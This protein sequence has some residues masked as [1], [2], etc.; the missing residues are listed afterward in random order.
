MAAIIVIVL[1]FYAGRL[2]FLL[3]EQTKRQH[4][5][6]HERIDSI[7]QSIQTIASATEQGQCNISEASIRISRLLAA[8]PVEKLPDYNSVYPAIHELTS[9]L[10]GFATHEPRKQLSKNERKEQD[11][12][13]ELHEAEL[14]V[15]VLLEMKTLK[16]FA[17]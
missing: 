3:N 12:I 5:V 15:R 11:M 2:L 4:K 13:R 8:L 14:Q 16:L 9:H 1:V 7:I 6:R 17:I 10:G